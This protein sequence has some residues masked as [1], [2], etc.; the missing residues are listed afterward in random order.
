MTTGTLVRQFTRPTATEGLVADDELQRLYI[1]QE[2][3]GGVYRY[4]AQPGDGSTNV[5]VEGTTEVGG[6]LIQDVKGLSIYYGQ[7]GTGYVVAAS[8]G[9]NRFH[10]YD[11]V[12][13][14][15]ASIQGRGWQRDRRRNGR[16]WNRRPRVRTRPNVPRWFLLQPG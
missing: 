10:L 4:G 15:P 12:S 9:G 11:R 8:Q 7:G 13:N 14:A 2:D 6:A 1:A 3:I 5:L 16:G